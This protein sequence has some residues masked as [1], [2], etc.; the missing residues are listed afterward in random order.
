MGMLTCLS[1]PLFSLDFTVSAYGPCAN[2]FSY[3]AA[4]RRARPVLLFERRKS[5]HEHCP[6]LAPCFASPFA[7]SYALRAP[8][9]LGL[10]SGFLPYSLTAAFRRVY[11]QK[12]PVF[13][14]SDLGDETSVSRCIHLPKQ[15]KKL[16]RKIFFAMTRDMNVLHHSHVI[17]NSTRQSRV[18][19]ALPPR[20]K[21]IIPRSI[22]T[23]TS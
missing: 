10:I 2:L 17:S 21:S 11:S 9:S 20:S 3:V 18:R 4:L 16:L 8:L 6:V 7:L 15:S 5:L 19:Q 12:F 13:N 23:R 14:Q 22:R 1:P